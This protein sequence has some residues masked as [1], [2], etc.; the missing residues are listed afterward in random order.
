MLMCQCAN[1]AALCLRWRVLMPQGISI[2]QINQS[3]MEIVSTSLRYLL[4][5]LQTIVRLGHTQV[6]SF[7]QMSLRFGIVAFQCG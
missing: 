7:L 3:L 1:W 4:Y 2:N 6:F 5:L